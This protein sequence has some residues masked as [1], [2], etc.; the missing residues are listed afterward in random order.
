MPSGIVS[1]RVRVR[2]QSRSWTH[3]RKIQI[4]RFFFELELELLVLQSQMTQKKIRRGE[5][6]ARALRTGGNR[7]GSAG[8]TY[9]RAR[10]GVRGRVR[11]HEYI[12][13]GLR[14]PVSQHVGGRAQ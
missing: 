4:L 1:V 7:E 2:K 14:R 3:H 5:V 8:G 9:K 10:R 12:A 6:G 13:S 11:L